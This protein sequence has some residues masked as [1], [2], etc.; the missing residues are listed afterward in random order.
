MKKSERV[1]ESV[2]ERREIRESRERGSR[3]CVSKRER[4]TLGEKG[5]RYI[6]IIL[7]NLIYKFV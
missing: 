4:E 7:G 6:Y 1:R 5:I 3:E 2:R